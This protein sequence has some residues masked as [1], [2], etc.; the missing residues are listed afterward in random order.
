MLRFSDPI[1]PLSLCIAPSRA[2]QRCV[3]NIDRAVVAG[4]AGLYRHSHGRSRSNYRPDRSLAWWLFADRRFRALSPGR[5]ELPYRRLHAFL[6]FART[7]HSACLSRF[8]S[9]R[10]SVPAMGRL[11]PRRQSESPLA[12]R[13][14]RVS[15]TPT[16]RKKPCVCEEKNKHAE[17]YGRRESRRNLRF[18]RDR[19][20]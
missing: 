10:S 8:A 19:L 5:A 15:V 4:P 11:E 17:K 16:P 9:H 12:Q 1:L 7:V 2:I 14:P 20:T 18:S 3:P 6:S 13:C